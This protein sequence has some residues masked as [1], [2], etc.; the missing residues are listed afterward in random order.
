LV[1]AFGFN[2]FAALFLQTYSIMSY[3]IPGSLSIT[4]ATLQSAAADGFNIQEDLT[5]AVAEQTRTTASLSTAS[6]TYYIESEYDI[7]D[8]I[9]IQHSD[10]TNDDSWALAGFSITQ[11][12]SETV[13]LN[14]PSASGR[15]IPAGIINVYDTDGTTLIGSF[16]VK[17]TMAISSQG[18]TSASTAITGNSLSAS[19]D[20]DTAKAQVLYFQSFDASPSV[21]AT[22]AD[23]LSKTISAADATTK[24]ASQL[25]DITTAYNNQNVVSAW[26]ISISGISHGASNI[27]A[28]HARAKGVTTTDVFSVGEK[29]VANTTFAYAVSVTDYLGN[30]V[31]IASGTVYGVVKQKLGA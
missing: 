22:T 15:V 20:E 10:V 5:V 6:F 23:T 4:T 29:I 19:V 24:Y 14:L 13:V 21:S 17:V 11:A 3:S 7:N 28:Q 25:T 12:T 9:S 26:T 30:S 31:S 1:S 16:E 27:L 2:Y 8:K 18:V